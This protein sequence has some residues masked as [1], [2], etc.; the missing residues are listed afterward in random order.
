MSE[1]I[2]ARGTLV[3]HEVRWARSWRDRSGGLLRSK[4]LSHGEAL[5]LE[6]GRQVHTIGMTYP[7]DVVFCDRE[8]RVRHVVRHMAPRRMTRVVFTARYAVEL[9]AGTLPVELDRG[10]VLR[11]SGKESGKRD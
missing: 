2:E 1:G 8:W 5:V 3:A 6:P 10:M 4:P 9:P 11:V 7:I